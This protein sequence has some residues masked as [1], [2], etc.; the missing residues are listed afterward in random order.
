M[1]ISYKIILIL[2]ASHLY[3]EPRNAEGKL[4]KKDKRV[5]FLS[6]E[7]NKSLTS[8]T[9]KNRVEPAQRHEPE[10]GNDYIVFAFH[11]CEHEINPD[12]VILDKRVLSEGYGYYDPKFAQI[13]F[14]LFNFD[15]FKL[16]LEITGE[17]D[18]TDDTTK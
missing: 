13:Y 2:I 10:V 8:T 3:C 17:C 6:N 9:L 4:A 11:G 15:N 5:G 14:F 12:T 1:I 18:T 7:E 16:F